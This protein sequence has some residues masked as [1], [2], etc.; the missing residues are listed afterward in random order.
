MVAA[1]VVTACGGASDSTTTTEAASTTTPPPDP[2]EFPEAFD[3]ALADRL[4]SLEAAN[5]GEWTVDDAYEALQLML[6]SLEEGVAAYAPI[7]LTRLVWF[8]SVNA[9]QLNDEQRNALGLDAAEGGPGVLAA[10]FGIDEAE[11]GGYQRIV[12]QASD[13][14][15]RLTGH[16]YPGGIVVALSEFGLLEGGLSGGSFSSTARDLGI[17]RNFFGSDA[18]FERMVELFDEVTA[19]GGVACVIIMGEVFRARTAPQQAAAIM[20]EV[21]HCHQHIIHPGG[22]AAFFSDRAPWMDEGYASWAGEAFVGGTVISRR[23]WDGYHDGIGPIGGH[24]TIQAGYEDI[25]LFSYLHD[26]GVDGWANFVRY[27]RDIRGGGTNAGRVEAILGSL[28]DEALASWAA[29]S[30]RR[31]DLGDRWNYTT[32][33]G[34]NNSGVARMPRDTPVAEGRERSFS[35]SPGEQGTYALRPVLSS[36]ALLFQFEM[37]GPGLLRWPWGEDQL[38]TSG[39]TATWCFGE[40]CVC[41]DGR[42]LGPVAPEFTESN[43]ILVT[44]TGGFFSATLTEPEEECE[45]EEPEPTAAGACPA[46]VWSAEP[47]E[48][49]DLLTRSYRELGVADPQYEGG[50]VTMSF[51]DD[52][53]FRFD[54]L[55][56]T[57]TEVIDG[58]PARFV[59]N[60]GSFGTW[61]AD[62]VTLTVV[63]E[64]QDIVL[65]LY[66]EGDLALTL[67]A[68]SGTG[69]GDTEYV[70]VSDDEMVIDPS[71]SS[72][73][74]PFP[75]QWT[76]VIP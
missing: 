22:P 46:G 2:A 40:E 44:T 47:E 52:G 70:C 29:S 39:T 36:G 23:F 65:D 35:T 75:R 3:P 9:D 55:D 74:W 4:V 15:A 13:E 43:M 11:R 60:G 17:Y 51:F 16:E 18:S 72:A 34:L 76:R 63:V 61:E 28:P 53:T 49:A 69:G 38:S 41:D 64:G 30:L 48:V 58:T 5:D 6:P 20:H 25:A 12:D 33:P 8:L 14:F 26:N 42:E 1:L 37:T 50:A 32:G 54:Y 67:A 19:D 27:F 7:D 66:L 21:V 71:F 10:Y 57:F 45:E 59:L 56:T 73:L 68:P 62:S 24:N 31:A